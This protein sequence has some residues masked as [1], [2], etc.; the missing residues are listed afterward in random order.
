METSGACKIFFRSIEQ[1][2]LKY[3]LLV[4]DGDTGCFRAVSEECQK[5][6]GDDYI[7]NKEECVGH[8]QKRLG[9]NL[10]EY[11]RKG[12]GQKLSD[13]K[14]ISG[15]GRLT[16]KVID[17]MQNYYGKAIRTIRVI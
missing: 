17:K 8:V 15:A 12:K 6:F 1:R 9:T 16:D 7:V 11:K 2:K 13:G 14:G 3:V 5:K 10:R 4:G